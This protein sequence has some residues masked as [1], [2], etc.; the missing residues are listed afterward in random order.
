VH[1]TCNTTVAWYERPVGL[2]EVLSDARA[3][4]CPDE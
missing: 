4:R 2:D 3:H 1:H